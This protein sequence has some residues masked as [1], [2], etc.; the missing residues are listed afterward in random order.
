VLPGTGGGSL[1]SLSGPAH[2]SETGAVAFGASLAGG[3]I[4]AAV[5][6]AEADGTLRIVAQSGDPVPGAPGES[7]A[8]FGVAASNSAGQ[9]AFTATSDA[10]T[11]GVF[12][13]APQAAHVP[14]VSPPGLVVLAALLALL[15]VRSRRRA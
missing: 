14:S 2:L 3:G 11:R 10:G 5:F 9:V 7:F 6:A 8:S 4:A 12:L 1:E 13:A 15:G